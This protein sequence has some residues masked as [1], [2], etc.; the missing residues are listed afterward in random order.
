MNAH[1]NLPA[2]LRSLRLIVDEYDQK[3]ANITAAA[4]AFDQAANDIQSAAC[5]G[6]T[7]ISSVF[8]RG[9]PTI[10][11]SDL[12]RHLLESAWRHVYNG[13]NLNKIAPAS[14]RSKFDLAMKNPA[15]FTLD[16]IGATFG[17]YVSDPR[18]HILRG[19]A[20]IF[21]Q[22][23]PAFKSHD[24][25]KIGVAGLPKRVILSN[26]TPLG[27]G[28]WGTERLTDMLKA[29][30]VF[31]GLPHPSN[32]QMRQILEDADGGEGKLREILAKDATDSHQTWDEKLGG[33]MQ[34]ILG[35]LTLKRYKNGNGHLCFGP[36]V[37]RAVNKAL[38]EY[39]G[40][41]L[42]D[43]PEGQQDLRKRTGTDVAKDLQFYG[44]PDIVADEA[45][46]RLYPSD[47][48]RILEPSCGDGALL[49][50]IRRFANRK[51]ISL[52]VTGVEYDAT[53]AD[54]ARSKGYGVQTANFLQVTPSPVFDKVVMNPPFYGKHY[55]KHV[56]HARKFL[57]PGG[58]LIA[59]LP[60]TAVTDH[61]YIVPDR[62]GCDKWKDLPVGSFRESGTNINTGIATLFAVR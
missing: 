55:Q 20:E 56:E 13:L 22:L 11:E 41:V 31:C 49:D 57:K 32:S 35:D 10:H 28:G 54:T 43:C 39:Y 60:I 7:Y 3:V 19:L 59:I 46:E 14:D 21:V 23:D 9:K 8:N 44:T 47:G 37:L 45:V 18:A 61:G 58:R 62:Y 52:R 33:T 5:I 24:K 38:A 48:D 26:V 30:A 34:G 50:A 6:G 36:D 4:S 51:R 15:P 53:R 1:T 12:L 25:M 16:N 42:P 29:I 17:H 27:Y 40:D 2:Q